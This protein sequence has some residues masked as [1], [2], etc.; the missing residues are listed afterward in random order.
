MFNKIK[1]IFPFISFFTFIYFTNGMVHNNL[2]DFN[3][4]FWRA[5]ENNTVINSLG[6]YFWIYN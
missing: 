1:L 6:N 2:G 4:E 5:D 3:N